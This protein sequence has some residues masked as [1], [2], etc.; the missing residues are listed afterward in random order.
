MD[1]ELPAVNKDPPS[2]GDLAVGVAIR[3]PS[4]H[5]AQREDASYP[6]EV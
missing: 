3:K 2:A 5:R 4:D 1:V 6:S